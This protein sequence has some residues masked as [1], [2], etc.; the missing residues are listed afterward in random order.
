MLEHVRTDVD[1]LEMICSQVFAKQQ[2]KRLVVEEL[3]QTLKRKLIQVVEDLDYVQFGIRIVF[4]QAEHHFRVDEA[5]KIEHKVLNC[6]TELIQV[7]SKCNSDVTLE[8]LC[9]VI[10]AVM[11]A[12]HEVQRV[13]IAGVV[14]AQVA[15]KV[16]VNYFITDGR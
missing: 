4:D 3:L 15:Y 2:H 5:A 7:F 13:E 6:D 9:E 12:T 10:L 11:L 8:E 1:A 14:L 16:F